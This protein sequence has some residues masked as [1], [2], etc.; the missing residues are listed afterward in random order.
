MP[1][2]SRPR[3]TR[4]DRWLVAGWI[5]AA[6]I[7]L[8]GT[9]HDTDPYWQIRAGEE[10][11]QGFP[12]SRPD[13]WSWAPVDALFVPNSPAWNIVLALAW[14]A[15]G[16]WGLYLVTVLSIAA[17]LALVAWLAL[18]L[19]ARAVPTVAVILVTSAGVLPLLSPRP[20]LPAQSLLLLAIALAA[21]WA[22][23]AARFSWA[24]N[25]VVALVGGLVLS[26][27]GNWVHLS[28]STL[29]LAAAAAWA[30]IWL[31]TGGLRPAVRAALVIGGTAGLVGGILAGP[32]GTDVLE[33]SRVVADACRDLITEWI[34]P[35]ERG[36]GARWWPLA[37]VTAVATVVAVAWCA[38]SVS[39]EPRDRRLAVCAALVVAALPFV[40]AGF[41]YIRFILTGLVTISPLLALALSS[42]A[43]R[44][45]ANITP[46][47]PDA[48]YL[49]RRLPEW[50]DDAFWR[51]ILWILLVV[52]AP[53]AF[54]AGSRHS[55]PATQA[56]N[57]ALPAGC[58]EFGTPTESAS[59]LLTRPDVQVW[60]DGRADYWGRERLVE[61]QGYLYEVN[62][63]TLVPP[64]TT[65]VVLM[66]D[67]TDPGLTRLTAALDADPQWQ[68]VPGT[69]GG[70]LWLPAP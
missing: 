22:D 56:T 48:S 3:T 69:T 60:I 43:A 21:W 38:R 14:R 25:G 47:P 16:A 35:F 33:R 39:R 61:A 19:G 65:C 42:V 50:T 63:P 41:V 4:S 68:R 64:G 9:V 1:A 23:R 34:G 66:D 26:V 17:C 24:V 70:N 57:D 54:Y 7:A 53:L 58:R 13:T 51:V 8:A 27:A 67:A 36:F 12:L 30:A 20:A 59:I 49:R 45:H 37:V 31:L 10:V 40:A 11:L 44:V 15:L 29:A 55:V 52:L 2:D 46:A 32:Y 6:S 5:G 18:R 62:Q 28:W